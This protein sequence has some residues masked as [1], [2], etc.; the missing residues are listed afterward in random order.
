MK[1]FPFI[2][3]SRAY[4]TPKYDSDI[5]LVVLM[6]A[7]ELEALI[8]I[9]GTLETKHENIYSLDDTGNKV[10]SHSFKFGRLN[11][12]CFT[13]PKEFAGWQAATVLLKSQRPV[14][15]DY[16]I[17]TIA[18]C[19]DVANGFADGWSTPTNNDMPPKDGSL[20]P[21]NYGLHENDVS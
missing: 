4:G 2:T 13:D 17:K 14:T 11:L 15:R 16:A 5:D 7:D 19:I 20:R 1:P 18:T 9:Q 21:F 3:G 10:P 6:P 8:E 12:I